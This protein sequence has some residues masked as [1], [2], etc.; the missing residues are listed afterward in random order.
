MG[1]H[2]SE[3]CAANCE[4]CGI[5]FVYRISKN[6]RARVYCSRQCMHVGYRRHGGKSR[7]G[8]P[9][10]RRFK[11]QRACEHCGELYDLKVSNTRWCPS[12]VPSK[13][14]RARMQHYGVS[15]PQWLA[16]VGRFDG[17]CW[18]CARTPGRLVLDHDHATGRPRGALCDACNVALHYVERHASGP[19]WWAHAVEYLSGAA[20]AQEE[21]E[22]PRPTSRI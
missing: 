1:K 3:L 12:C 13:A 20:D 22:G 7:G 16:M 4:T 15:E 8:A 5:E 10:P 2:T 21:A 17:R 9:V 19:S 14:A 11:Q 6:G 18:V